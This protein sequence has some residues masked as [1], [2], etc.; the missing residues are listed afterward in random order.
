MVET[1]TSLVVS[2][3]SDGGLKDA[4]GEV[5]GVEFEHW[6]LDGPPP[7]AHID[8]V[9]A[10]YLN[11]NE[12]LAALAD[13]ET[14]LLQWQSIG[15]NGVEE[16]LPAGTP[17]ANATTVHETSTAE[18]ALALALAAQR[19]IPEFVRSAETHDWR[20][21]FFTSLADRRVLLVGYG[22]V[23]KAVEA[24]LAG[25]ETVV[26]R[27]ARTARTDRNLAGEEVPVRGF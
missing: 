11:G 23:G 6:D 14:R 3:P 4:L 10:P 22:G 20:P 7:R 12:A 16:Y 13:V 24:R 19:G 5:P 8:I 17:F 27:V 1:G 25:F 9:V 15:Y 26:D 2:L 21:R 18:L